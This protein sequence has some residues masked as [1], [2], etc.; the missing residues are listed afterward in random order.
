M[1]GTLFSMAESMRSRSR[2]SS[3]NSFRGRGN[4]KAMDLGLTGGQIDANWFYDAQAPADGETTQIGRLL[5][6]IDGNKLEEVSVMLQNGVL[7]IVRSAA[8]AKNARPTC[9]A[10]QDAHITPTSKLGIYAGIQIFFP[11]RDQEFSL[12][13]TSEEDRDEWVSALRYNSLAHIRLRIDELSSMQSQNE[14]DLREARR[15]AE[16]AKQQ[17]QDLKHDFAAQKASLEHDKARLMEAYESM[18]EK[19]EN[20]EVELR[21]ARHELE[22]AKE[23]IHSIKQDTQQ[24]IVHAKQQLGDELRRSKS[25]YDAKIERL[26]R[27]V[28]DREHQL[29]SISGDLQSAQ[30]ER[31]QS[32]QTVS[33]LNREIRALKSKCSELTGQLDS[34]IT[35]LR[36]SNEKREELQNNVIAAQAASERAHQKLAALSTEVK[37]HKSGRQTLEREVTGRRGQ[38]SSL[39]Q[40]NREFQRQIANLKGQLQVQR[41]ESERYIKGLKESI[42]NKDVD[43]HKIH[44]SN[45]ELEAKYEVLRAELREKNARLKGIQRSESRLNS[46]M[47]S[48]QPEF[49]QLLASYNSDLSDA[50]KHD[51]EKQ[52]AAAYRKIQQLEENNA[53]VRDQEAAKVAVE[54]EENAK[55]RQKL[56]DTE[57]QLQQQQNALTETQ[58]RI[59]ALSAENESFAA[60]QE[61]SERQKVEINTLQKQ[62]QDFNSNSSSME[63]AQKREEALLEQIA[64]FEKKAA[65]YQDQMHDME[66]EL[67]QTRQFADNQ[68]KDKEDLVYKLEDMER[69]LLEVQSRYY[70]IQEDAQRLQD[71]LTLE[72]KSIALESQSLNR[73]RHNITVA[74]KQLL[75]TAQANSQAF[76][77]GQQLQL[78]PPHTSDPIPLINLVEQV[79]GEIVA[80]RD[81]YQ[82]NKQERGCLYRII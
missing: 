81:S 34:T 30:S 47:S 78:A 82:R 26:S 55:L 20:T 21:A 32:D 59:A 33:A 12:M 67:V 62:I 42:Q 71:Q 19:Q 22:A 15:R 50:Q 2:Q 31:H 52:L 4:G 70:E 14:A 8:N 16:E 11:S 63:E 37:E 18:R 6:E 36:L 72:R 40:Q 64:A 60:L 54:A 76:D 68:A 24:Q 45:V 56:K 57:T 69:E 75:A 29:H 58:Q 48:F 41:Q 17:V 51:L 80:Q 77:N 66:E 74:L 39:Q 27:E 13:T 79:M 43:L 65:E 49:G 5:M 28:S 10:L 3:R 23:E 35:K 25:T 44:R 7:Q 46:R 38:L 9:I 1:A 61:I 53:Q 73:Q